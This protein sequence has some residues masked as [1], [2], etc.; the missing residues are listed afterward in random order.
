VPCPHPASLV[1][2]EVTEEMTVEGLAH[3]GKDACES[4][5]GSSYPA[6]LLGL[7]LPGIE[8]S[9]AQDLEYSES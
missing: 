9:Q 5:D 3:A 7:L 8:D 4:F 2:V 1:A 6:Q